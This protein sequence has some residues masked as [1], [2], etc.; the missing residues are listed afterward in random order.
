MPENTPYIP[1]LNIQ[2]LYRNSKSHMFQFPR[3]LKLY[4]RIPMRERFTAFRIKTLIIPTKKSALYCAFPRIAT[5]KNDHI[6]ECSAFSQPP[7]IITLAKTRFINRRDNNPSTSIH[8]NCTPN[9][10]T[11]PFPH[12][13]NIDGHGNGINATEWQKITDNTKRTGKNPQ[14]HHLS[15]KET[16]QRIVPP[17]DV[18]IFMVIIL[19]SPRIKFRK[20]SR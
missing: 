16:K 20:N 5:R 7:C 11:Y 9:S 3:V 10:S 13:S 4:T 17:I 15:G 19:R 14:W 6:I 18:V 12:T 8:V 1:R 2:K